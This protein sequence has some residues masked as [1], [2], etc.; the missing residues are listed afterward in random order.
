MKKIAINNFEEKLYYEKLNNGFEIYLVP[1]KNK[2]T[3]RMSM[4]IKYGNCYT[5]FRIDSKKYHVP[6]GVA[7][8]LEHK[9]F[10][11]SDGSNPFNYYAESGTSVNACTSIMYTNYYCVGN[12]NFKENLTY[13]LNWITNIYIT[14]ENVQKE[15]GIILE[16]E[17]MYEDN[18]NRVINERARY[19]TFVSDPYGKK[20]VG[21]LIDIRNITCED[22]KLAYNSFYR[23]DN[24]FIVITGNFD[25]ETSL[26]IIK[27]IM[28]KI[29]KN[30]RKIEK[31]KVVE[32]DYVK[33]EEETFKLTVP[34]PMVSYNYKINKKIFKMDDYFLTIY[35]AIFLRLKFGETSLFLENGLKSKDFLD[36]AYYVGVTDTHVI[37]T[38]EAMGENVFGLDKKIEAELLKNNFEEHDFK[39][40]VACLIASEI[41]TID[42]VNALAYDIFDDVISY[43]NYHNKKIDELKKLKYDDMQKIVSK[44]NLD[45]KATIKIIN[46][47]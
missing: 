35:L 31:E 30:N 37:L 32:E 36:L 27:E 1:L 24:M 10:E 4:G 8:F 33:R 14:K 9:L 26:V 16:E 34:C 40:M 44:L 43:G 42:N 22:L 18:P 6:A 7:H 29:P 19:N 46:N 41:N 17:R 11:R 21:E 15:K 20:V 28:N 25:Y 3:Y 12:N 13:L 38:F 39:R 47:E 5:D 45:H 23:P 2:S